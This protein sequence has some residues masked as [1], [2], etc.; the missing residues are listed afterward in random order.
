MQAPVLIE[1]DDRL[2]LAE[3]LAT[4]VNGRLIGK[5]G[6]RKITAG[7]ILS[8]GKT[9]G[10][11]IM[12]ALLEALRVFFRRLYDLPAHDPERSKRGDND[13]GKTN[14]GQSKPEMVRAV[15]APIGAN[16]VIQG[17]TKGVVSAVSEGVTV[18]ERAFESAS[19]LDF[20]GAAAKIYTAARDRFSLAAAPAPVEV[21]QDY[22]DACQK[23]VAQLESQYDEGLAKILDRYR[24]EPKILEAVESARRALRDSE[25][26]QAFKYPLDGKFGPLRAEATKP[27]LDRPIYMPEV[28][29]AFGQS[30]SETREYVQPR[31]HQM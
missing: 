1:K 10:G 19:Q 9:S 15:S 6:F 23:L 28:E 29:G 11:G 18:A 17:R 21:V 22:L 2:A 31:E 13:S 26:E 25:V 24:K 4:H 8:D 12:Q 14:D 27:H 5:A 30:P 3:E 20:L 16:N 7:D